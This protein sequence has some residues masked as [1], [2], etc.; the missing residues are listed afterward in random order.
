[1][2]PRPLATASAQVWLDKRS[3]WIKQRGQLERLFN[4]LRFQM[5]HP[6]GSSSGVRWM[7]LARWVGW[8]ESSLS[9]LAYVIMRESSGR[10]N[11]LNT[12]SACA[13]LLQMHPGWYHGHWGYPSF[14]PFDPEQN[15]K[16]GL[17]VWKRQGWRP[18]AL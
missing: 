15:L 3:L 16:A 12:S 5:T 18:W 1:V 7:P 17:W 4:R 6:G 9:T 2:A 13:G 14:N 10:Q 11:A 8:P